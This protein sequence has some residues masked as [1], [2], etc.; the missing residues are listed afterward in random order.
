MARRL[1]P[2]AIIL[3]MIVAAY[4][5]GLMDQVS[6]DGLARHRAVWSAAVRDHPVEALGGF[7]GVYT[8]LAGAGLP[9]A[10][11]LSLA[12]GMFFGTLLGG[13]AIIPGSL[14]AAAPLYAAARSSL[15][16]WVLR[17]AEPDG[18]VQRLVDG[19]AANGFSFVLITRLLPFFP[20]PLVNVAAGLAA[21]PVGTYALATLLSATPT[22]FIY[23][24]LGAGLGASLDARSVRAAVSSPGVFLPLLA[25]SLLSMIPV[26]Y[27]RVR[28]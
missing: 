13:M 1:L 5:S 28:R 27:Q 21:V 4:G 23:A 7:I 26:V 8:L 20:F 17:R 2:V 10:L 11:V 9:V 24:S 19:L 14:M 22:S 6:L 15:A 16:P 25:L 12:A 3:G 18:R